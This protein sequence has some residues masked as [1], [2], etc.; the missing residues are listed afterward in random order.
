MLIFNMGSTDR[1]NKLKRCTQASAF[2]LIIRLKLCMRSKGCH[3]TQVPVW[4][5]RFHGTFLWQRC[6]LPTNHAYNIISYSMDYSNPASNNRTVFHR[7]RSILGI[8]DLPQHSNHI[9]RISNK[10]VKLSTL[11]FSVSE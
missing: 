4:I 5:N 1:T 6:R 8:I 7:N 2:V 11:F 3:H 10:A 9:Y